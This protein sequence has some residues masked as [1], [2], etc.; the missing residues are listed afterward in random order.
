VVTPLYGHDESPGAT[1]REKSRPAGVIAT[2]FAVVLAACEHATPRWTKA[3]AQ[4]VSAR[5]RVPDH[6]FRLSAEQRASVQPGFDVDALERLLASVHPDL[7]MSILSDFQPQPPDVFLGPM[8]FE[9]P[10]LQALL[11]EVWAPRWEAV[12]DDRLDDPELSRYPGHRI[13]KARRAGQ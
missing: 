12:P 4:D 5:L 3:M 7:R 11:D 10:V 6:D 1:G 13:A 2:E 8:K 9:D